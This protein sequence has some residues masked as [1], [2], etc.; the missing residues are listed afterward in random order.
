VNPHAWRDVAAC[1]GQPTSWFFAERGGVPTTANALAICRGCPVR[2]DCLD[3]ALAFEAGER[4]AFGVRA[5]FTAAERIAMIRRRPRVVV[6]AAV[7]ELA[8]V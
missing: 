1:R 5:G 3:D 7:V 8:A 4:V 6:T 2:L